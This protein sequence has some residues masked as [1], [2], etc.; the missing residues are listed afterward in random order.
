MTV[1]ITGATGFI[2]RHVCAQLTRNNHRVLAMLRNPQTQLAPLRARVEALGG[3]ADC[4]D[5]VTGDLDQ[6]GLGLPPTLPRL[7]AIVHLGARFAWQLDAEAARRTNVTGSLAVAAL[8]HSQDCRLVFISGFMLENREHLRRVG[9][10]QEQP[11]RTDWSRVY[12][13]VGGYEASKLEAAFQVRGYAAEHT[14]AL[15]EVQP[16]TVAGHS[17]T[18]ELDAAQPLFALLDNLARGRMALVPGTPAHW[19]PLVAVDHLAGLIALAT[20]AS[21]PPPRLLA[22]D[23][24]TPNLREL[25][26]LAAVGLGRRP[27]RRFIPIPWL[28]ALLRLPGL[29]ALMNTYPEALHFIQPTRF[30]TTTIA[31]FE[32]QHGLLPPPMAEVIRCSVAHYLDRRGGRPSP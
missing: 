10:D 26:A 31:A 18:G 30:D 15:V 3:N 7:S 27:P 20:T 16:A 22:L 14:L 25:L 29:A 21:E 2:G 19:L 24:A 28:A 5:A 4:L 6:P 9:I 32:R 1:L 8:A 11:E 12:H 17:D 13:R 23:P